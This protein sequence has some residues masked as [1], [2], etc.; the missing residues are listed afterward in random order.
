MQ[1][2]ALCNLQDSRHT[3]ITGHQE[4]VQ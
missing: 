4:L 3:A 2:D 1:I